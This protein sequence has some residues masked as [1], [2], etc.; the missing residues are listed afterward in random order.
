M[1]LFLI[2]TLVSP[3]ITI[4]ST[5]LHIKGGD[6][7][8]F[9]LEYLWNCSRAEVVQ[10]VSDFYHSD[11]HTRL[12]PIEGAVESLG[13]LKKENS[14]VVITSRPESVRSLTNALLEKYFPGV[15]EDIYFL[16]HYH[17]EGFANQTKGEVCRGV[18]VSVFIEDAIGNAVTVGKEGIPV[19]LFDTPWNQGDVP[20]N[21]TRVFGW[22]D[23]LEKL[24]A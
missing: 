12:L 16:S 17:G 24:S 2:L 8:R 7:V 3:H 21:T 4:P 14:L 13:Q 6:I 22:S 23:V 18:G 15:F 1:T 10:R 19:L 9:E 11:E 5:G 20:T